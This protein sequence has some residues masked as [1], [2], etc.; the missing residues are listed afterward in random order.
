MCNTDCIQRNSELW[1]RYEKG[2]KED[3][4]SKRKNMLLNITEIIEKLR[5]TPT[6]VILKTDMGKANA[7][8]GAVAFKS[9]NM[10]RSEK[11][12]ARR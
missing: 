4:K 2:M 12:R 7:T 9:L 3:I 5:H 11:S 10:N 1:V 8:K 6:H